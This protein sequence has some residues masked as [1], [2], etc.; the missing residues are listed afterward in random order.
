MSRIP[1]PKSSRS[2]LKPPST[3]SKS[4]LAPPS[5]P[6]QRATHGARTPTKQRPIDLPED[7][8]EK[9]PALSI[10]EAI[11]LRRAEAKKAQA[12]SSAGGLSNLGALEDALPVPTQQ[13]EEEDLLGR[14]PLRETIEKARSTGTL[15]IGTRSLP[16]LPSALF[17]IH[18]N[19]T[20]D[21]LKSVPNE[22]PLPPAAPAAP[23][24]GGKAPAWFEAQDLTILKAFSNDIVEIQHEISMFGSL[25]V[26]D[27]HTNKISSLP[28]T[29]ADLSFL[30]TLDLSHNEL[31]ELP[32]NIWALPE[33]VTLNISHNRLTGLPLKKPF[34]QTSSRTGPNSYSSSA[35]FVPAV[36]R[37]TSPLPKLITLDA[38]HNQIP[39]SAIDLSFPNSLV[40]LDL[41]GNPSGLSQELL[42]GLSILPRLKELRFE[43]AQIG[44]N[45]LSHDLFS[46]NPF[47]GLKV[48]DFSETQV[49]LE[50]VKSAFRTL[51]QEL[52]HDF[53]VDDPPEGTVKIL[54]GKRVL[55]E[56]WEIELENRKVQ[57]KNQAF[58]LGGD[59]D[60][61]EPARK[62]ASPPAAS[63][64]SR[65]APSVPPK[66]APVK[67]AWEVE[68]EQAPLSEGA[69]RRAR[70]VA[71]QAEAQ[72]RSK[73]VHDS[74]SP[75]S[76]ASLPSIGSPKYYTKQTDTLKLPASSPPTKGP[77]H[78]RAFS[79]ASP[80]VA[81]GSG[82]DISED[83]AL[84]APTL[85]LSVI[86]AQPF[87][88][89]LRVLV[90]T[91]RRL[92]RSFMVP[93]I[94]EEGS[95]N[96][97]LPRLEELDLEGCNF[98]DAVTIKTV[99]IENTSG[100]NTP[101]RFNEP[102]VP[103]L[104]KL[105]PSLRTLNLAYNSL[106]DASFTQEN[107]SLLLLQSP[108]R[109][110]LRH[111]RLRGNRLSDLTGFQTVAE[112]FKGNREV[113][114]WKLEELDLRDNEIGR[115]PAEMGLM[116]LDV[117]LVEGNTFRVP[118]RRIWER[119]GTKGLLSWLRGRIE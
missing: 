82:R 92:D 69:K 65:A 112:M 22:P 39:S 57:R 75:T 38:S 28:K 93:S 83:L 36:V 115:L 7:D 19:I 68:A 105:F 104:A 27:L 74:S 64:T 102:L 80:A 24:K 30:T 52:N 2:S 119:E 48:L 8:A 58:G 89:T 42:K 81:F 107:L 4:R 21:A 3:P 94:P 47:P 70:A 113:P 95:P 79:V 55:K 43:K 72:A 84:P 32:D 14:L 50:A 5:T 15:N 90:L 60:V 103:T 51:R 91:N 76:S 13:P 106:S 117:F 78:A 61:P 53:T 11:A 88:D 54:V 9:K 33:L 77:G 96:L 56:S 71:A 10:K 85:P 86:L 108:T 29:I 44:D 67:E 20:P 1:T 17:E 100:T 12:S 101:P 118:Q 87:A 16:C 98:G 49:T 31:S 59:W 73:A 23:R 37:S 97:F 66:H 45:S 41:S 114:E 35:F 40:K 111:L 62:P 110:G 99:P 34:A 18:L 109:P 26:L 63:S 46:G 116:P 6:S 25:K